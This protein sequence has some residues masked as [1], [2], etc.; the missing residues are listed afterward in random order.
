M[1]QFVALALV[2]SVAVGPVYGADTAQ[3]LKDVDFCYG[4]SVLSA[5][6]VQLRNQ[7][8][9]QD[10]QLARRKGSL[11]EDEFALI[12]DI[13]KQVYDKD[14]RDPFLVFAGIEDR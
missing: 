4:V 13:T 1:K 6:T 7:G 2:G 3:Q 8:Q 12:A 5:S 11:S 14:L 10:E 9:A